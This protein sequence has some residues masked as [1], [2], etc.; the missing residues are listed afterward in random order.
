MPLHPA[1]RAIVDAASQAPPPPTETD[2]RIASLRATVDLFGQAGAGEPEPVHAVTDHLADGPH[3][4]VPVRIYEPTS[5]RGLPLVVYLHGGG[6][7][8]GSVAAWDTVCRRI[9]AA[10]G[11]VVASVDYRL[12]PEF[13]FPVPLDDCHAALA[14]LVANADRL[15]IDPARVAVAG[16][17]AGGNLSAAVALRCRVE[18]PPLRAQ[19]LVYPVTDPACAS[20]SMV[21]NAQGYLLTA[22]AMREMWAWYLGPDGDENDGFAAVSRAADYADLPPALV[23]TA[24]YDPLRDEGESYASLL[25]GFDVDTTVIRYDGMLHGFLNMREI[26]PESQQAVVAIAEFLRKHVG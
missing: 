21:D 4:P 19:V 22:D 7:V 1:M 24:E 23:I 20:P 5:E 2:A 15:G 6:W 26:V 14:W 3:G 10:A 8:S 17:S 25:D 12:A 11:M 13:P 16:D 9:A 18:G